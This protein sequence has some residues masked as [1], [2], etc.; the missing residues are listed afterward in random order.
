MNQ[1][2]KRGLGVEEGREVPLHI[3]DTGF[4]VLQHDTEMVGLK[5]PYCAGVQCMHTS[6]AVQ[7][8]E[9]PIHG[10]LQWDIR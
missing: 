6:F 7:H 10:I 5:S 4:C 9:R 2:V 8:L 3:Q 1:E